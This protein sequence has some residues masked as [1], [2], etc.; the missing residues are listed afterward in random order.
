MLKLNTLLLTVVLILNCL[1]LSAE[2]Y[3][4]PSD[5]EL[6]AWWSSLTKEQKIDEIRKLDIIEHTV[7]EITIP[8][9]TAILTIDGDLVISHIDPVEI[10]IYYLSY[11][12]EIEPFK[13]VE[14]YIPEKKEFLDYLLPVTLSIGTAL[15]GTALAEN[16]EPWQY[17]ISALQ[18]AGIGIFLSIRL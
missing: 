6:W 1:F 8:E 18:G 3:T 17:G 11:S 12:V 16:A 9:M 5:N 2:P 10:K 15:V 7:P 4:P 13:I 14:F